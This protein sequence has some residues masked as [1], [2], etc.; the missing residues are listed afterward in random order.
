M[1]FRRGVIT[2]FLKGEGTCPVVRD[3]LIL[4]VVAGRSSSMHKFYQ[5]I[6]R[7]SN[8][9]DFEGDSKIISFTVFSP[10]VSNLDQGKGGKFGID[11]PVC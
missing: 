7:Q 11:T 5:I 2:I 3:V 1:F 6:G 10:T 8:S 9:Q 4:F